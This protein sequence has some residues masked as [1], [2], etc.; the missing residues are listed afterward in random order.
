MREITDRAML[1]VDLRETF[2]FWILNI[3]PTY[4]TN[5]DFILR[6][7]IRFLP[8]VPFSQLRKDP[9]ILIYSLNL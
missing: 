2:S 8:G 3:D 5:I 1:W 9:P 4:S 6:N 7:T